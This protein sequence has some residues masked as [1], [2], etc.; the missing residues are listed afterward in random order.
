M[1]DPFV[2]MLKQIV[3]IHKPV[4]SQ[5]MQGSTT[6]DSLHARQLHAL[7]AIKIQDSSTG[8]PMASSHMQHVLQKHTAYH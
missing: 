2:C 7:E 3:C 8:L 1:K 4:G 5:Q 6:N